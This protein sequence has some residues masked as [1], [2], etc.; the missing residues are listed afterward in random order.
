M[1]FKVGDKVEGNDNLCYIP[2][3]GKTFTVKKVDGEKIFVEGGGYFNSDTLNLVTDSP[4]KSAIEAKHMVEV[5]IKEDTFLL[6]IEEAQ[7]LH[8]AL[9][10]AGV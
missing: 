3:I 8:A 5:T 1:K 7:N 2:Y 10:K 6:T 4:E 9:E